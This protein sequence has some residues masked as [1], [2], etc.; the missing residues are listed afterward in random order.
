MIKRVLFFTLLIVTGCKTSNLPPDKAVDK[1]G[2]NPY[3][4]IDGQPVSQSDLGKYNPTDIASLTTY[5]DK[6]AIKRFGEKAKDG[7]V[8]IET[9]PFATNKYETFFKSY[10][11][12]YEQM[13]IATDRN[14]IQYILNDRVL[15]E[16]FEGDLALLNSKLLKELKIIDQGILLDKYKVQNKKVGVILKADRPKDLYNSQEKF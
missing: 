5:Y 4:E 9:K 8:T 10:S 11:K 7:A 14:E 15:T 12:A 2:A 3:F 16:N 1:L 6:D 13:I